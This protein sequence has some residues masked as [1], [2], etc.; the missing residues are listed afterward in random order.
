MDQS[1][2]L[3]VDGGNGACEPTRS[4]NLAQHSFLQITGN[5]ATGR[6]PYMICGTTADDILCEDNSQASAFMEV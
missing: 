6:M 3:Y 4:K 1:L 2:Y 5:T